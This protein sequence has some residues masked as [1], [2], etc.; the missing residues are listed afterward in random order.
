MSEGVN[1]EKKQGFKTGWKMSGRVWSSSHS[2]QISVIG[3]YIKIMNY[4][5][6]TCTDV[7]TLML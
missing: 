5:V 3:N 2:N 1:W 4:N 6:P 7:L